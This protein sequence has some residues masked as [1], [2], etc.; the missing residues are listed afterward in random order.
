MKKAL[1]IVLTFAL[2]STMSFM[3]SAAS[4]PE[5][6][7]TASITFATAKDPGIITPPDTKPDNM[8]GK[9]DSTSLV[10][11]KEEEAGEHLPSLKISPTKTDYYAGPLGEEKQKAI[12]VWVEEGSGNP[13]FNWNIDISI[14]EFSNAN[15]I[16]LAGYIIDFIDGESENNAGKQ[17]KQETSFNISANNQVT[18]I[19]ESNSAGSPGYSAA[20]WNA[21][22]DVP[23]GS[24]LAGYNEATITW[25]FRPDIRP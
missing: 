12:S 1:M 24:A 18:K 8:K 19:F 17:P 3:I 13:N 14:T 4:T 25:T 21:K 2:I 11:D 9:F 5:N 20:G 10:F 23:I 22:I 7:S 15:N 16:S 6:Q